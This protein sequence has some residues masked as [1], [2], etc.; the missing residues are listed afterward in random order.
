MAVPG[1]LWPT[2]CGRE[3]YVP[4]ESTGLD[5]QYLLVGQ[6]DCEQNL[7]LYATE[8]PPVFPLSPAHTFLPRIEP[9]TF[10]LLG[11]C[12]PREYVWTYYTTLL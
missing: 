7:I 2:E 8:P 9:G 5:L 3:K 6:S 1:L 4:D 11:K 10:H 12:P